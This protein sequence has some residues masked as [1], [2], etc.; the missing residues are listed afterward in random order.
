MSKGVRE[1]AYKLRLEF[2]QIRVVERIGERE[3]PVVEKGRHRSDRARALGIGTA[4]CDC[5]PV[6]GNKIADL[7]V[8]SGCLQSGHHIIRVHRAFCD[9]KAGVSGQG[10]TAWEILL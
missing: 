1:G 6:A 10:E 9:E 8:I 5:Q 4:G 2:D 7:V 3:R